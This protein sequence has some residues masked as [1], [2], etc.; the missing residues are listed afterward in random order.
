MSD[1]GPTAARRRLSTTTT[2]ALA[3]AGLALAA[4]PPAPAAAADVA[5]P[6]VSGLAWRSG[7]DGDADLGAWRGRPL[8]ARLVFIAH[9]TWEEMF[10]KSSNRYFVK[11]CN[12]RPLCVVSLVMFP[13]NVKYQF[14]ACADGAFDVNYRR[15]AANIAAAR[16]GPGVAVRLGW[17]ANGPASRPYHIRGVADVA[18]YKACFR[19]VVGLLREAN[20]AVLVEWTNAKKGST[21]FNVME[22]YP[23]DDV[24]DVMGVHYYDSGVR[25]TTQA[26]WDDYA[27]RR[28]QYGGPWGIDTWLA[29]ARLRGKKL[30]V[31]EWGVWAKAGEPGDPDNALYIRNMHAFFSA[32]AADIAYETYHNMGLPHQLYPAT[33]FPKAGAQYRLLW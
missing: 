27:A 25:K 5:T 26:V 9:K 30:A 24:V 2:A 31:T 16:T 17:E 28:S 19:R 21:P 3:A 7:A 18:P 15:I 8:D 10:Y 4:L 14:Q 22:T 11:N 33:R 1:T 12:Q 32:N 6:I 13:D 29:E 23:G 20:P